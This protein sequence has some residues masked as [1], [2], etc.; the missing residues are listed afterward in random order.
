[1]VYLRIDS[2]IDLIVKTQKEI[3][4]NYHCLWSQRT[5][6]IKIAVCSYEHGAEKIL[7]LPNT[8]QMSPILQWELFIHTYVHL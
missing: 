2:G 7:S 5:Y 4:P 8:Q 1:M 3:F 6:Y